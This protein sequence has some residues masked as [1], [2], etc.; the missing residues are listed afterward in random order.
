VAVLK[1]CQLVRDNPGIKQGDLVDEA[2]RWANLNLSTATWIT[3]PGPKSPAG[4]LWDRRKEGRGYRCYPNEH[5]SSAPDAR[6][7][8]RKLI[9]DDF[10]QMWNA[11][12]RPLPGDLIEWTYRYSSHSGPE[13]RTGLLQGFSIVRRYTKEQLILSR[14][15]LEDLSF[16]DK[17]SF[18]I[19]AHVLM[20]G[21]NRTD[22]YVSEAVKARS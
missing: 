14:D 16:Y 11:A 2:T 8:L 1:A 13:I 17:G 6:V 3:T 22:L 9:L 21:G 12:L 19:N 10:D 20:T 5:T 7:P 15:V 4:I 18:H